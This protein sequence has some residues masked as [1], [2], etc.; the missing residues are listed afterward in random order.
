MF[1]FG[2][3]G[4]KSGFAFNE[5]AGG[6]GGGGGE[7]PGGA[8]DAGKIANMRNVQNDPIQFMHNLHQL[9]YLG[10]ENLNNINICFCR[11]SNIWWICL[12][13]SAVNITEIENVIFIC[14]W[15][16]VC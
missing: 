1:V 16:F 11:N 7:R 8:S 2:R 13:V 3:S 5:D 6:G 4:N 9:F 14:G 12:Q 10:L 15:W